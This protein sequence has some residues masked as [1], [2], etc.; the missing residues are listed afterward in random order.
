[1]NIIQFS[2]LNIIVLLFLTDLQAQQ[3]NSDNTLDKG[4]VN[5]FFP[6]EDLMQIGAFYYPEQWSEDQWERDLNNMADFGFD[7]THFAEFSWT[8]L[9]PVEGEFDFK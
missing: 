3:I 2:I 1:M 8:F 5:T 9:E 4:N 6:A 7:F